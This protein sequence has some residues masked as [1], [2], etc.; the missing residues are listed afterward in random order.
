MKYFS[1][2]AFPAIFFLLTVSVFAQNPGATPPSDDVLKISTTLIQVDVT[3]TDRK[4]NIVT[5]L[6][7]E[8]FEVYE[9]G[10]KQ[11]ITNFSFISVDSK[12]I[13]KETVK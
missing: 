3:V 2:A 7:P 4:G 9:N 1:S 6:K 5:D 13:P 8:D 12:P 10:K 11:E